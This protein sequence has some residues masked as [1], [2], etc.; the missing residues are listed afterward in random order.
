MLGS[1][2]VYGFKYIWLFYPNHSVWDISPMSFA[3]PWPIIESKTL[4]VFR[5][6]FSTQALNRPAISQSEKE[7]WMLGCAP[8][9]TVFSDLAPEFSRPVFAH[10]LTARQQGR[11][12][13]KR[14]K[15]NWDSIVTMGWF[16]SFF[17]YLV[18]GWDPTYA[19]SS[20]PVWAYILFRD[21]FT[22]T[23]V[24]KTI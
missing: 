21:C 13:K 10:Q 23:R 22:D 17:L 24:T 1:V 9:V 3:W 8:P 16:F 12:K 20:W 15:K 2:N 19:I 6:I 11:C 5:I 4:W 18:V 7:C 14:R